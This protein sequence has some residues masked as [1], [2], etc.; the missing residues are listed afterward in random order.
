MKYLLLIFLT[1]G[2][3]AN[4][5]VELIKQAYNHGL[6]PVP[7]NFKALLHE[8]NIDSKEL[9][10]EKIV[11]GKKLF[12]EKDLSLNKDISCASCHSFNKGGADAVPTAIGHKNRENPFHLNTPTVLNTAFSKNLF[13]N[14]SAKSLEV[15]AKGP[16]QA[17]FEMAITPKLARQRIE[18]KKEYKN[19]FQEA[20]GS[21]EITFNKITEA[22]SAYERTLVTKGR[23]DEFLLGE[24]DALTTKEKEGL[25]LFIQKGCVGCHNGIGL[26]GQSTRSFPLTYHKIWSMVKPSKV[27][28][29]KN[30]Y[31]KAFTE[32]KLLNI[33]SLKEREKYIKNIMGNKDY[34]LLEDGFFGNVN[35]IEKLNAI[36]TATCTKCHIEN[37]NKIKKGLVDKISFPFENKGGFLGDVKQLKYFR[38]PLLRN[39]VQTKPYFHNGTVERLEDAIKLMGIHQSRNNL[40]DKEIEKII[41]FLKAVDGTIVEYIQ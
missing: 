14:G 21:K 18:N 22:I 33:Q 2:V 25:S 3:F 38:V 12:F 8:L 32:T 15:Q 34:K 5:N 27:E 41:S 35:K 17:S 9:S 1:I 29:I 11:L 36:T 24:E 10:K 19:M 13:W 16:L 31:K 6:K 30:R 26:G 20:F 40:S 37:S 23:Y 4:E 28:Q 39:V 7:S